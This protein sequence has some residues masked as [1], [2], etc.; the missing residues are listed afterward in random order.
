M[1]PPDFRVAMMCCSSASRSGGMRSEMFR[2]IASA[3]VYPNTRSAAAFQVWM[4]PSSDLL[5]I[6]S[7]EHSTMAEDRTV[8]ALA[9][10]RHPP[11][12]RQLVRLVSAIPPLRGHIPENQH[13]PRDVALFVS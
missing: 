5:M 7:S 1:R 9:D 2:P 8:R 6:A 3:A 10:R 13:A 11:R 12:C 4:G